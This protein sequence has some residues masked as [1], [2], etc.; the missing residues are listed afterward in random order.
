MVERG[1][2]AWEGIPDGNQWLERLRGHNA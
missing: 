2:K 1:T